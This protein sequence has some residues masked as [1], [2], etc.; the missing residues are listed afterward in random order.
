MTEGRAIVLYAVGS[1]LVADVE[2]S[3]RRLRVTIAAAIANVPG[4]HYLLDPSVLRAV[5]DIDAA[6]LRFACVV[7]LFTPANRYLAAKEAAARG[8]NMTPALVDPTAVVASSTT[9]ASGSYVNAG[10]VIGAA[11]RIGSHVIV[12]RSSSIGHHAEIEALVS[13]GPAAAIAG[14][15][16]IGRGALI[17]AGA[18]ILPKIQIGAGCIVGAGAVVTTN[19]PAG[20]MAVGNP[21]KV[22]RDGLPLLDDDEP[23]PQDRAV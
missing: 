16:R 8:F 7:P 3:C 21:A 10:A 15:V 2:E 14:M 4:P 5:A 17:G 18:V 12:N 13:I 20:S 9:I 23:Q 1:P 11:A 6:L 19:L 22:V